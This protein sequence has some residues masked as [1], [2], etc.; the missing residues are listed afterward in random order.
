MKKVSG[1]SAIPMRYW[2]LVYLQEQLSGWERI[3][4]HARSEHPP[5][6][7]EKQHFFSPLYFIK[8]EKTMKEIASLTVVFWRKKERA[9]QRV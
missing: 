2:F 5:P 1:V 6:I 3:V 9:R 7:P 4:C 8:T